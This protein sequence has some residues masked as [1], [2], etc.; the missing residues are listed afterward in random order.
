MHIVFEFSFPRRNIVT[1]ALRRYVHL[2]GRHLLRVFSGILVDFALLNS[3]SISLSGFKQG[4]LEGQLCNCSFW[5]LLRRLIGLWTFSIGSWFLRAFLISSFVCITISSYVAWGSL[6]FDFVFVLHALGLVLIGI[7]VTIFGYIVNNA[8]VVI[9]VITR[10][11]G[12]W[13]VVLIVATEKLVIFRLTLFVRIRALKVAR[14]KQQL[15]FHNFS[16]Y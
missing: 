7:I 8:A 2:P 3:R 11:L 4:Y 10:L 9:R 16:F 14:L 1:R 5:S 13:Y 12:D 6:V 15:I